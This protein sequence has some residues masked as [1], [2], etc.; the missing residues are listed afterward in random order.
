MKLIGKKILHFKA[1]ESTNDIAWREAIDD[2]MDGT[3]I[4]AE[5]QTK[6]RGRFGRLWF[7][8]KDGS[9]LMSVILRHPIPVRYVSLITAIGALSVVDAIDEICGLTA[10][11]QFPNDVILSGKKVAGVL[12]ESRFISDKPDMFILGIGVNINIKSHQFPKELSKVATSLLLEYGAEISKRAFTKALLG[13]MDNWYKQLKNNR[14]D[15]I[16]NNWKRHLYIIDRNVKI[17]QNG[18]LFNGVVIESDPLDGII[19]RLDNGH[20]ATFRGEH[21][22]RCEVKE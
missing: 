16:I 12:V 3:V 6:G 19:L 14:P 2:A 22:E 13:S 7:G 15:A 8:H 10:E 5:M 21:I 20:I 17:H 11:I 9:L 18:K 1:V 4:M